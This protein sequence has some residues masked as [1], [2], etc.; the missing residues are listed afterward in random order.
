MMRSRGFTY[1]LTINADDLSLKEVLREQER[2]AA[3]GL[4]GWE[5]VG[6]SREGWSLRLESNQYPALRRHVHY[7]LCYGEMKR[8]VVR[9]D[10]SADKLRL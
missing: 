2:T 4:N 9:H 3:N 6:Q 8:S 1:H 7:P 10:A 5:G